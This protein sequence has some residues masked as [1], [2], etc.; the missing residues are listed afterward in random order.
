MDL[1]S[2]KRKRIQKKKN[3]KQNY[4][5]DFQRLHIVYPKWASTP[6]SERKKE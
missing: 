3:T 5:F 1:Q 4:P 2:K 6:V